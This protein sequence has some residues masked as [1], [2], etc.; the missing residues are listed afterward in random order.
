[1]KSYD[2][3]V[4]TSGLNFT[5]EFRQKKKHLSVKNSTGNIILW[6]QLNI[7]HIIIWGYEGG[8]MCLEPSPK[9][10]NISI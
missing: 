7:S 4:M 10:Y 1:M 2:Y 5:T 8:I 3:H 9:I 6:N